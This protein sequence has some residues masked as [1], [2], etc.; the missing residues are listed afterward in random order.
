MGMW[1]AFQM[2]RHPFRT[3]HSP[4][5][6]F[7][8]ST[9]AKSLIL[10]TFKAKPAQILSDAAEMTVAASKFFKSCDHYGEKVNPNWR[11]V[12]RE[13]AGDMFL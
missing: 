13:H 11:F 4:C 10:T 7:P 1:A 9:L 12:L 8:E 5:E 6:G 3:A 2:G